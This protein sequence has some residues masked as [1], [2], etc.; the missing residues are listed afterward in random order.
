MFSNKCCLM[1]ACTCLVGACRGKS[2]Y[3]M[4][5]LLGGCETTEETDMQW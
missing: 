4:V 3:R 1:K 2:G 5:A